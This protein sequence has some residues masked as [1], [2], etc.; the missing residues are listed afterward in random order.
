MHWKLPS[1][2]LL[3]TFTQ[4]SPNLFSGISKT[5]S[6]DYV[7]ES[8]LSSWLTTYN[9][10]ILHLSPFTFFAA[11]TG[12]LLQRVLI[13]WLTWWLRQPLPPHLWSMHLRGRLMK[14]KHQRGKYRSI[15]LTTFPLL[16]NDVIHNQWESL[17]VLNAENDFIFF[18]DIERLLSTLVVAS[19]G[20]YS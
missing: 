12:C 13:L 8:G 3:L 17:W 18:S 10:A 2:F 4:H 11:I 9:I 15:S 5:K 20:D 16:S 19:W 1:T 14:S 7:P 6:A